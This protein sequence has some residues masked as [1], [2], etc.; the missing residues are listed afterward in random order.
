[1]K[2]NIKIAHLA[3]FK[4]NFGDQVNHLGFRAWF[5]KLINKEVEWNEFEIRDFYRGIKVFNEEFVQEVN[6]HQLFVV[7]GGNYFELW[8]NHTRTGCSIDLPPELFEQIKIPVFFNAV[9][10]DDGQGVS[11]TAEKNFPEFFSAIYSLG[12]NLI[13]VRN[14]GSLETL[15]NHFNITNTMEIESIPDHGFFAFENTKN[16]P[17]RNNSGK[18]NIGINLA[19]DMQQL[20]FPNGK[21]DFLKS[22][23]KTVEKLDFERIFLIPHIHNDVAILQEFMSLFPDKIIREKITICTVGS[24]SDSQETLIR[25]YYKLNLMFAM[26][27]HA[28]VLPISLGVPTIGLNSYPQIRKLY[29]E[30]NL[31]EW[32]LAIENNKFFEQQ[33]TNAVKEFLESGDL[34]RK[35]FSVIQISVKNRRTRFEPILLRWMESQNLL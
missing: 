3:S 15:N 16:L 2:K 10:V 19:Q 17:I 6:S 14:D 22:L 11:K 28:N 4:G 20:R 30:I 1:M 31:E 29:G 33:L 8:P 5:E 32:C 25:T 13:T 9:G 12:K 34:V 27:F 24:D 7:G 26:R 35:N 21:Q 18:L 23:H